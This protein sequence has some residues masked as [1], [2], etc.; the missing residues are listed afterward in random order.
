M[1]RVTFPSGKQ[2]LVGCGIYNMK[3]DKVFIKDVVDRA[4]ALVEARGKEAFA[5]LRDKTGPFVFLDTYVFVDTPDGVEVVN[6]AQPSVEG[7]SFKGLKDAS[8]KAVADEYLAAAMK[9]GTAWVEYS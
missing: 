4:S 7:M 8:G 2:H 3:M 5:H 9:D 1:K 6:P